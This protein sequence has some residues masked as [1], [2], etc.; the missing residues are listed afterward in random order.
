MGEMLTV[1]AIVLRYADYKENDRML[2]LFSLEQGK[3]SVAIKGV[4]KNGSKLRHA[5]EIFTYGEYIVAKSKDRYTVTQFNPIDSF[6][7]L[8]LDFDKLSAGILMLNI[9]EETIF[10]GTCDHQ[11]FVLVLRCL[12][13]LCNSS[14]PASD[15]ISIFLLKYCV[16]G[17][18]SPTLD[19]CVHC[20]SKTNLTHFDASRGGACCK[21]CAD[22]TDLPFISSGALYL[23]N[24]IIKMP[25]ES[26]FNLKM[27]KAQGGEIYNILNKYVT[28]HLDK[29]LKIIDYMQRYDLIH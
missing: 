18:Y 20:N 13:Q 6:Y 14:S 9:C 12:N 1:Q 2:T 8:R 25:M 5:S 28:L 17:G 3:L 26:V 4:R 27:S 24:Q 10:E 7:N 29:R 19:F 16:Y 22:A 11:L 21:E 23:M 15:I